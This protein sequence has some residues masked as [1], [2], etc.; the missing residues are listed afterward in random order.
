MCIRDRTL[1]FAAI[2][3]IGGVIFGMI[4]S[5]NS[6]LSAQDKVLGQVQDRQN[7]VM[8]R[9]DKIEDFCILVDKRLDEIERKHK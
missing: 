8:K 5:Q 7:A 9:L 1:N 4:S 3:V 6:I 2:T